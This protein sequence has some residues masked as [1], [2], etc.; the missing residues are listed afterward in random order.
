MTNIVMSF[1]EPE[2]PDQLNRVV[3]SKSNSLAQRQLS[4]LINSNWYFI[5]KSSR[6]GIIL[7]ISKY[8]KQAIGT[9]DIYILSRFLNA[10]IIRKY[11]GVRFYKIVI[12]P[13]HPSSA[14]LKDAGIRLRRAGKGNI[15][16]IVFKSLAID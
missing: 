15:T 12:Y 2:S 13:L 6:K 11:Y 3:S 4:F 16:P 7:D 1:S 10:A 14:G 9:G 5:P 8:F